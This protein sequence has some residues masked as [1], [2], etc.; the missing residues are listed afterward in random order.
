MNDHGLLETTSALIHTTSFIV[1]VLSEP[2]QNKR[3][4]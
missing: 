4:I 1:D 2:G 3:C